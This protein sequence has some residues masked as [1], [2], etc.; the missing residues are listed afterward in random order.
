MPDDSCTFSV[1][2]PDGVPFAVRSD[3]KSLIV[4]G[5]L[6]HET[7]PVL[8][9]IVRA[10]D[11]GGLYEDVTLTIGLLDINEPPTFL[12]ISKSTVPENSPPGTFVGTLLCEDPEMPDDTCIF[13]IVGM[14]RVPFSVG[15]D[16]IS[17]LVKDTLDYET[18][19]SYEINI[20][21]TDTK[22]LYKIM[23]LEISLVGYADDDQDHRST[24]I[25]AQL[26]RRSHRHH[27]ATLYLK[28]Y[29]THFYY[30][31]SM[32]KYSKTFACSRC[33]KLWK[34]RFSLYQQEVKCD[35]KVHYKFPGGAYRTPPTIFNLLQREEDITVPRELQYIRNCVIDE[36]MSELIN[37]KRL[38]KLNSR[39]CHHKS[40][41][42]FPLFKIFFIQGKVMQNA[43][44]NGNYIFLFQNPK[45]GSPI[46]HGKCL[47]D[48]GKFGYLFRDLKTKQK[49]IVQRTFA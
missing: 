20:K 26:I 19:A 36:L 38:T 47:L 17:L 9:V 11:N 10:T 44:L 34:N 31:E 40:L 1:V 46:W 3:G 5:P 48:T 29:D 37:D 23:K 41:S 42:C 7:N 39:S 12:T 28:F 49:T 27:S 15:P 2:G 32:A 13:D 45:D 33:Q 43:S 24:E 16:D 30:I 22:G 25:T 8:D 4:D 18:K 21:A 35:G 14:T 6:D